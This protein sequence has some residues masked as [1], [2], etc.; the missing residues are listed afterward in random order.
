MN[1]IQ[2]GAFNRLKV[3]LLYHT[4]CFI[5]ST[6]ETLLTIYQEAYNTSQPVN[7]SGF[8]LRRDEG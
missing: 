7:G 2:R 6:K 4:F 1:Y 8:L 3:E 5:I